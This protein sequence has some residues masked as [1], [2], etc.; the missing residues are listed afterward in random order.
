MCASQ[1]TTP[2]H[3][4][5]DSIP[6]DAARAQ[7]SSKEDAEWVDPQLQ[8]LGSRCVAAYTALEE[9]LAEHNRDW[10]RCQHAVQQLKQCQVDK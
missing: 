7:Q 4:I 2:G 6:T 5:P 9:C 3:D 10:T 1:P 8:Q